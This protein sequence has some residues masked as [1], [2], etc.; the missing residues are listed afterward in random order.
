MGR[1]SPTLGG[2]ES[3]SD[4]VSALT[5]MQALPRPL[6]L[7]ALALATREAF[8]IFLLAASEILLVS[9][10]TSALDASDASSELVMTRLADGGGRMGGKSGSGRTCLLGR[11]SATSPRPRPVEPRPRLRPSRT[12]RTIFL[13]TPPEEA[14]T[15]GEEL[16]SSEEVPILSMVWRSC[17]LE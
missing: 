15:S 13:P 5:W 16:P 10:L 2:P 11:T 7:F 4:E 12:M 3:S 1:L 9:G 14:A 8:H 6:G 17:K